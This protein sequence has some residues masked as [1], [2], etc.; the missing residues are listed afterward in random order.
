VAATAGCASLP[1]SGSIHVGRSL[2]GVVGLDSINSCCRAFPSR[3]LVGQDRTGIIT[4]YLDALVD[5]DANY[6]IARSFLAPGTSWD[7]ASGITLYDPSSEVVDRVSPTQVDVSLDRIGV[8]DPRGYYRVQPGHL[9]VPFRVVHEQGQWRISR[10]PDGVLLSAADAPRALTQ[11]EVYYLN[12]TQDHLVPVPLLVEP[13]QPGLATTLIQALLSGPRHRDALSMLTAAPRGSG[14]VGNVPIGGDG[15]AEVN[16]SGPLQQLS[17]IQLQ[18]LSAQV[19]WTLR[20]VPGISGVR[21]LQNGTPVTEPGVPRDQA[22][23]AWPQYEPN[24]APQSK[25]ALYSHAG[26]VGSIGRGA[27]VALARHHVAA[28]IISADGSKVAALQ[29]LRTGNSLVVGSTIGH[30]EPRLVGADISAPT[31]DPAG[32]VYVVQNTAG[33]SSVLVVPVTGATK[34]VTLAPGL[35]GRR[36]SDLAISRDGSRVALVVGRVGHRSLVVAPTASY[37][38]APRIGSPSLV[39][40]AGRDARGVAWAGALR[41]LTT[42]R[43]GDGRVVITTTVD[44][45]RTRSLS[46]LGLPGRPWQVAAAPGQPTLATA[47]GGVWSLS[48]G[49]WRRVSTGRDPSYAG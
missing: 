4:G 44:G 14:L 39:V 40:P 13:D 27:P 21:L 22:I 11:A 16:L 35:A 15:V 25:G 1:T 17:E 3:P 49:R 9:V 5:S 48:N 45:Y 42:A 34:P 24:V 23:D 30:A 47:A 10:L 29:R 6:A 26:V 32:D 7:A 19:V 33:G 46:A 8:I 28:P 2:P 37:R 31:F 12:G 43:R 38:E 36:I 20:Q 18:R 41:I